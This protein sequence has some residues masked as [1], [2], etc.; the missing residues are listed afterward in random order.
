M[1]RQLQ[2]ETKPTDPWLAFRNNVITT[3][4][5]NKFEDN[6]N[7]Q[8]FAKLPDSEEYLAILGKTNYYYMCN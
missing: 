4:N 2:I 1:D 7:A 8:F 6:F 3:E 5:P